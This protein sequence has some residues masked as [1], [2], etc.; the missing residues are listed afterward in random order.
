M[1]KTILNIITFFCIF[2]LKRFC[3]Q[4]PGKIKNLSYFVMKNSKN[5]KKA[6]PQLFILFS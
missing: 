5:K 6:Q 3:D 2:P 4:V 1:M